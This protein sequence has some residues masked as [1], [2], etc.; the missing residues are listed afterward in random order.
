M[1]PSPLPLKRIMR[2]S[3]RL[4]FAP[5]TGAYRGIKAEFRRIDREIEERRKA[6]RDTRP[7]SAQAT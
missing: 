2:D 5:V 6:E 7:P 4:Y 3:I 1:N